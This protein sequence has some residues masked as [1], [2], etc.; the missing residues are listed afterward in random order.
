M[1]ARELGEDQDKNMGLPRAHHAPRGRHETVATQ[2]QH[3]AD[4]SSAG[5][6]EHHCVAALLGCR[7]FAAHSPAPG[8]GP[9][10]CTATPAGGRDSGFTWHG[11]KVSAPARA[12]DSDTRTR[13]RTDAVHCD[14]HLTTWGRVRVR[15]C[16]QRMRMQQAP[17]CR[18]RRPPMLAFLPQSVPAG[19]VTTTAAWR[20][21]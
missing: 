11:E 20:P 12:E 6:G 15:P 9:R 4:D 3:A 14:T 10:R 5:L 16:C 19:D 13:H 21:A 1:G 7:S 8:D 2:Q 17:T 18:A